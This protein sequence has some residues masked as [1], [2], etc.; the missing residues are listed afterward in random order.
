[1]ERLQSC[2]IGPDKASVASFENLSDKLS[3]IAVLDGYRP[4][5]I[6]NIFSGD[7]SKSWK[8]ESL[9]TALLP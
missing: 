5:K 3:I 1:M 4:F 6:L 8:F 7:V 2:D 9:D